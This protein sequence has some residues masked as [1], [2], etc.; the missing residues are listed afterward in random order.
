MKE[1][2]YLTH[3]E[4]LEA[5]REIVTAI[6]IQHRARS[7][8]IYPIPRGGIP[9]AYLVQGA[10]AI[11]TNRPV[12]IVGKPI[13]ANCFV[14]D[15]IDSGKTRDDY[16]R[17]FPGRNFYALTDYLETPRNGE[18]IVFPW[19]AGKEGD[20]SA[21][22]IPVRLLQY[23]GE[24]VTREGL[25]DTPRRFLA[26][27]KEW[28]AGYGQDPETIIKS[29]EDG[30]QKYDEMVMV[31]D[32][33]FYSMCEHHLAPFFGTATIA[34]VPTQKV[35]GL[36]K[37]GR[38]L[39][40]FARRLQVQERLTVQVADAIQVHLQPLGVAVLIR[41]RHLCMES[42]GLSKQGHETETSAVR[43]VFR[44][45]PEARSEFFAMART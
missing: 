16:Q 45:K 10:L 38:L 39:D 18:W 32:I 14:D 4:C 27:W 43:G 37:L 22:D 28:T 19:E 24:D 5:A 20:Q 42:R 44:D 35:V 23:I 12:R 29:F 2:R 30:A 17:S 11:A 9:V 3:D 21:D 7:I 15:I 41:A 8:D 36:S 40:V 31:R 1:K 25:R 34:Y 6:Q 13:E 33:P 26:A